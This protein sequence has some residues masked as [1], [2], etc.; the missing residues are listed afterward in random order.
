MGGKSL[1][2]VIRARNGLVYGLGVSEYRLWLAG[3][4]GERAREFS[5]K[6]RVRTGVDGP[7]LS[8]KDRVRAGDDGPG[9]I[10]DRSGL[11]LTAERS[12]LTASD[13]LDGVTASMVGNGVVGT[14]WARALLSAEDENPAG[15][16]GYGLDC[17]GLLSASARVQSALYASARLRICALIAP[18]DVGCSAMP[19]SAGTSSTTGSG[20][21]HIR[22]FISSRSSSG[23]SRLFTGDIVFCV[24]SGTWSVCIMSRASSE[25][26][27]TVR[28]IAWE[29]V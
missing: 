22:R 12:G 3:V 9:L 4:G 26:L 6:D 1:D 14:V 5:D 20:V 13:G 25:H 15:W 27:M 23:L 29:R 16:S 11:T 7:G 10:L 18:G 28:V 17:E 19:Q 24:F 2:G 8:E 21:V